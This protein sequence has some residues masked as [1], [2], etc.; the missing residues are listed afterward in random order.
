MSNLKDIFFS[1]RCLLKEA[2][3]RGK[4]HILF[5]NLYKRKYIK[6]SVIIDLLAKVVTVLNT[7]RVFNKQLFD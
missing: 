7:F 6:L 2:I 4:I 1:S 5:M 3:S